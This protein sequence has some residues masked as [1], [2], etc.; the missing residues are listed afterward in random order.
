MTR[1]TLIRLRNN[2]AWPVLALLAAVWVIVQRPLNRPRNGLSA[3]RK[4][5]VLN[6]R[7]E[8]K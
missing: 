1:R 7:K 8:D 3:I 5:T 2:I 6:L 4:N